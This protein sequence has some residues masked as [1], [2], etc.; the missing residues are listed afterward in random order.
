VAI[1][2]SPP[3]PPPTRPARPGRRRAR[4]A[5]LAGVVAAGL[6]A[7]LLAWAPWHESPVAPAA[8]HVQSPTATQI[9]VSWAPSKGGATVDRYLVLRDGTQVG[10]VPASRTSYL[11]DGL[12]PGT[13]HRYAIVAASGTQRSS[14]SPRA[15]VTTLAPSPIGLSPQQATWTSVAFTWSPSPQGPDPDEYVVYDGSTSIATLPGTTDSY[16]ITGL[17]PGTTHQYRVAAIWAG[18]QS[19]RSAAIQLATL[20][21][22]VQGDVPVQVK[23]VS[24]PGG[25]ASLRPG[26]K[27]T[28]TWTFT[29]DCS[30]NRC[31]LTA[32]G[33][34]APPRYKIV[35]F[36]VTLN[37]SGS[38]YA[39]SARARIAKCGSTNVT[40]TVTL[41][42]AADNGAVDNGAWKSW[43]GTWRVSAPYTT[44][45]NGFCPS[46]AWNFSI[47]SNG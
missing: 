21:T 6:V 33:E 7:G 17:D 42:I 44:D 25:G 29:P 45:G 38:G 3:W 12:A 1:Q 15:R 43:H 27:W 40:D 32:E 37:A 16:T 41:K 26:Q 9:L 20:D 30:G 47:A 19:G 22:P 18:R 11:D 28:D 35:P 10:S 23:T 24:T 4:W 5:L 31:T 2:D 46:Q 36:T 14:P 13:T 34:W 8:V 39:G